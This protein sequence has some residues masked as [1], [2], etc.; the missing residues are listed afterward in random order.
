V[1]P[2]LVGCLET[3]SKTLD[4]MQEESGLWWGLYYTFFNVKIII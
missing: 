1:L 4:A 2:I 3:L